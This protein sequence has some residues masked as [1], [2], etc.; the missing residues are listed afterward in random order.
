SAWLSVGIFTHGW[1]FPRGPS[2]VFPNPSDRWAPLGGTRLAL[3]LSVATSGLVATQ[4]EE[5]PMAGST[6]LTP[7]RDPFALMR[8]MTSEFDRFFESSPWGSFRW[9]WLRTRS[10]DEPRTWMPQIDVVE[11][12]NRLIT[13]ID[14]P[15]MK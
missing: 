4:Q 9:P 14:L 11:R 8:Q 7:F 1:K 15:G 12:D 13:R 6:G 10:T 2:R 3:T 5:I